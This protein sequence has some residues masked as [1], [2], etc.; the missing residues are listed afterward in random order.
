MKNQLLMT[1]AAV[2]LLAG[3]GLATAQ[4]PKGGAEPAAKMDQG[5][6]ADQ[7]ANKM[8]NQGAKTDQGAKPDQGAKAEEGSAK[9]DQ[10]ANAAPAA[11]EGA[12]GKRKGTAQAPNQAPNKSK[13]AQTGAPSKNVQGE[14]KT[15][16][17]ENKSLQGDSKGGMAAE[18]SKRPGATVNERSRTDTST[19]V[20]G[21]KGGSANITLSSDQRTKIRSLVIKQSNAPRV[22]HVDFKVTVGTVVPRSVHIVP[23]PSSIVEIEPTWRGFMYFLV[24]DE[25]VIVEPDTLRIVA[26]IAA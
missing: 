20:E 22:A 2:A 8:M 6:K 23:V 10:G 24:G 15:L 14:G 12:K 7:G 18:E 26:V 1:V 21:R 11:D 17:G 13:S 5:G 16:S 3:T 25:V 4:A 19:T 9:M